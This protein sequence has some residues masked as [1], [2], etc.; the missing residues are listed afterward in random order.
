MKNIHEERNKH[1]ISIFTNYIGFM[2]KN[3]PKKETPSIGD[4]TDE[5]HKTF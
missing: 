2:V 4:F 5:Y 1:G 3:L